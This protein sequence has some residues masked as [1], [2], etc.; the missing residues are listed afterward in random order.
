MKWGFSVMIPED[1][2]SPDLPEVMVDEVPTS[3]VPMGTAARELSLLPGAASITEAIIRPESIVAVPTYTLRF[4][5]YTGSAAVLIAIAL[6]QASYRISKQNGDP[7]A[8]PVKGD[9]VNVEVASLLRS[10]GGVISR[11]KFFRLFKDGKLDWFVSR[12]APEHTF[13][14]GH[15]HRLPNTY[16]YRGLLLTPGDACDLLT[17][18]QSHN[19]QDHPLDTLTTALQTGRDQ[20]LQFPYRIPTSENPVF[21]QAVSVRDVLLRALGTARLDPVL[22]S[23][24]DALSMNLIRPES[25]LTIPWYWF[26]KVL[27]ELGDDMGVLYLMSKACCYVDWVHGQDRNTFWVPGGLPTLQGWIGSATLPAR[28][29][30]KDPSQRGRPRSEDIKDNS[31]YVRSWREERRNMASAYLCRIATRHSEDGMDWQLEVYDTRLTEK[32][33]LLRDHIAALVENRNEAIHL[34]KL[35]TSLDDQVRLGLLYRSATTANGKRLCH[36]DTLV[37]QGFCHSDTLQPEDIC[38]FDTLVDALN[39][40]FETV[41]ASG[42]CHFD[43]IINILLKIKNTFS[44]PKYDKPPHTPEFIT[45]FDPDIAEKEVV[46]GYFD[47][48][49]WLVEKLSQRIN[50]VLKQQVTARYRPDAFVSWLIYACLTDKIQSPLSFAVSRVLESDTDAGGPAERLAKL[51]PAQLGYQLLSLK[52]RLLAGYL[53]AGAYNGEISPELKKFLL[54]EDSA[55]KQ[56]DLVQRLIDHLGIVCRKEG[57]K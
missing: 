46:E 16:Q 23:L 4:V 40:H 29:P 55:Q 30:Q 41:I 36:F 43:T 33:S 39:C 7:S 18:L 11:A 56:L 28:I 35:L 57:E 51:A 25:F 3:T 37:E 26:K 49:G 53:G 50:P 21:D 14:D 19:L 32:D 13:E 1:F 12:A 27:P 20:I 34:D 52:T 44:I 17:W 48:K 2:H 31:E 38:H 6:R 9:S 24:C 8:Y 5:P 10:L 54:V 42:I 22:S 47:Q 15:I 45:G